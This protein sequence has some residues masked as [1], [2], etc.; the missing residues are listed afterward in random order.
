MARPAVGATTSGE[1]AFATGSK[2]GQKLPAPLA[3]LGRQLGYGRRSRPRRAQIVAILAVI[4]GAWLVYVFGTSLAALN[5]AADREAA[6][7]SETSAISREMEAAQRELVLVQTNAFQGLQARAYGAGKPGE[8]VFSLAEG[9]PSAP[10]ITPL[11]SEAPQPESLRPI[12][13]WLR[14][15]FGE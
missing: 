4:V 6:I 3:G 5:E 11:G 10:P 9:A 2:A 14:L 8:V 1:V 7:Q 15:L 13:S 12:D